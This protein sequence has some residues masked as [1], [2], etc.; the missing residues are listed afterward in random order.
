[1]P[2]HHL[3]LSWLKTFYLVL[4]RNNTKVRHDTRYYLDKVVK[5]DG[6]LTCFDHEAANCINDFS[7]Y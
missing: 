2:N 3:K 5:E 7:V 4:V 1:M 6:T